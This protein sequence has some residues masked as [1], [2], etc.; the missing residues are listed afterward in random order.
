MQKTLLQKIEQLNEVGIALSSQ[1]NTDK[2]LEQILVSAQ[3]LTNADGGTLYLVTPEK[4]LRFYVVHNNS[5][6]IHL[7]GTHSSKVNFPNIPLTDNGKENLTAVAAFVGNKQI[8]V[9][10]RNIYESKK[11][12][13]TGARKF[14]ENTGYRTQSMLAVPLLNFEQ[15][16][17]GVLQLINSIDHSSKKVI[18]F[19]IECQTLARSLASQAS[20]ALTNKQLVDEHK[21]LFESFSIMVADAIDKKSAHTGQHCKRVPILTMMLAKAACEDSSEEFHDFSMTEEELFE[22]NTAAWLHDCGKL[23]TPE[24][25]MEKSTK[26]ETLFDRIHLLKT[27]LNLKVMQDLAEEHQI[28]PSAIAE[29]QQTYF[30]IFERLKQINSG[31]EF[32]SDEDRD[33]LINLSKQQYV[34]LNGK[35]KYLLSDEELE[36]LS[37]ARGTLNEKERLKMQDHA[38]MTIHMLNLMPFPKGLQRV[39]EYAGGHHERMDG[40]G[41]PNHLT[42]DQLSIPARAMGIA[43]IFEALSAGDRPYKEAKSLSEC[44]R[45]LGFM[46]L[47]G[48]I[49]P[50]LFN[51]FIRKKVYLDY[52]RAHL[53]PSQIDEVDHSKIPGYDGDTPHNA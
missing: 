33:F 4:E 20:I 50:D 41:Y 48:H 5:L 12:D 49:D 2:L 26:L 18:P 38:A 42:R 43:D 29:R 52:A 19:G 22:L 31:G 15:E 3:Q 7:G 25:I 1:P 45:I 37:I 34:S 35:Q 17:I 32:L 36:N 27:R 8:M 24:Y 40:K 14:D 44:L 28:P 21:H 13:F 53:T 11:F 9:N 30:K 23:S 16:T 47:E 46:K 10:I 39:P 51:L 6:N